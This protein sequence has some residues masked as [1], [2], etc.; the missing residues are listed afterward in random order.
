[1]RD[2]FIRGPFNLLM[3]AALQN[4]LPTNAVNLNTICYL[5]ADGADASML[6]PISPNPPREAPRPFKFQEGK[7]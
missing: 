2:F 7:F 3:H 6:D 4:A 1:M 5:L